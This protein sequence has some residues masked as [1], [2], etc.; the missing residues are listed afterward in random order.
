MGFQYSERH[1]DE[2]VDAGFTVLRELI[3][4]SL[5]AD[6]RHETDKAR[7]IARTKYGAQAQRLQPVYAYEELDSRKFRDFLDLPGLRDAVRG[8]LGPDHDST[9]IMGVLLEPERDAWCTHWHRDWGYNAAH[10]DLEAFFQAT[11]N[12]RLFNQLNAAL[13]DDHSLWV[14]P[15]SHARRDTDEERAAFPSVPP[16]G[17]VLTP[18]MDA[19]QRELA[20]IDYANRMPGAENVLLFTGDVA[21][22][23]AC[24]WH[25]GTYVPYARRATLHD[26]FYGPEDH[27]WRDQVKRWQ[28]E[29]EKERRGK[30]EEGRD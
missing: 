15:G 26:G 20:C 13:Y 4:A 17:P 1:R 10:V 28:A 30:R 5:L 25:L 8:I 29:A 14:V 7:T 21:F 22:Y 11:P 19:A 2:Y 6:L 27:A 24:Q 3:P 9:E 18:E 12:L 16:P 23:R